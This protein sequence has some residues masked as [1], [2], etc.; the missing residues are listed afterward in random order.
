MVIEPE[1]WAKKIGSQGVTCV[2]VPLLLMTFPM[3]ARRGTSIARFYLCLV[4]VF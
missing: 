3:S 2:D 4:V 1:S